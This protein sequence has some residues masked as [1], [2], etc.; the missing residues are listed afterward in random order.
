[1]AEALFSV[2]HARCSPER[3]QKLQFWAVKKRQSEFRN[4]A[5]EFIESKRSVEIPVDSQTVTSDEDAPELEII[6]LAALITVP[7][8]DRRPHLSVI[9][10]GHT[11]NGLLDSGANITILGKGNDDLIATLNSIPLNKPL[12]RQLSIRTADGTVHST[13]AVVDIPYTANRNN[14]KG[15]HTHH[16]NNYDTIN[17]WHRLLAGF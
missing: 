14:K 3:L 15:H 11:I 10:N 6:E 16:S 5:A 13:H 7:K 17:T 12:T 9:I 1:M 2:W 8:D 4:G